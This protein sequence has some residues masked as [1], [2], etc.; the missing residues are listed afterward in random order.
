MAMKARQIGLSVAGL[1]LAVAFLAFLV[2]EGGIG[3]GDVLGIFGALALWQI[4]LMLAGIAMPALLGAEK[5]RIILLRLLPAPHPTRAFFTFYTCLAVLVGYAV[6]QTASGPLVRGMA[7]RRVR[8]GGFAMGAASS[9]LEQVFDAWATVIF[10]GAGI[11]FFLMGVSPALACFCFVPLS[12]AGLWPVLWAT[13]GQAR[14]TARRYLPARLAAIL[15]HATD[16]GLTEA[17]LMRKLYWLSVLRFWSVIPFLLAVASTIGQGTGPGAGLEVEPFTM[18]L[19]FAIVQITRFAI[20]TP[21]NIGVLEWGWTVVLV[22]FGW[23]LEAAA[24]F[25]VT[26]RIMSFLMLIVVL[27]AAALWKVSAERARGDGATSDTT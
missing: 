16:A 2:S 14:G 6:T 12:L 24:L 21:G 8:G 25:S 18:V 27:A 7:L 9:G 1:A 10:A 15:G 5:W 23:S 17:P 11:A 3:A 22:G 4:P 26:L 20:L 19:A 13:R